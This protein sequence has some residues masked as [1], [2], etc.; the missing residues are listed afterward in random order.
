M[1]MYMSTH[2]YTHTTAL[3]TY[4]CIPAYM[5]V[6]VHIYVGMNGWMNGWTTSGP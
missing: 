4:T 2:A 3:N 1:P 5:H 6:H